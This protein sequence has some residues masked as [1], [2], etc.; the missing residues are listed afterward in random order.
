MAGL[1]SKSNYGELSPDT[2]Q[3]DLKSEN[4]EDLEEGSETLWNKKIQMLLA[5]GMCTVLMIQLQHTTTKPERAVKVINLKGQCLKV[6]ERPLF[7][8]SHRMSSYTRQSHRGN[9]KESRI[10]QKLMKLP[11]TQRRSSK[12]CAIFSTNLHHRNSKLW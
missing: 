12:E 3:I 6:K 8:V 7:V 2:E 4:E 9:L 10:R 1:K 11:K 5:T